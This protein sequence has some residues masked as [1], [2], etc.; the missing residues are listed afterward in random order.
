MDFISI[1]SPAEMDLLPPALMTVLPFVKMPLPLQLG[2]GK[3]V[4]TEISLMP[5]SPRQ[6]PPGTGLRLMPLGLEGSHEPRT[7]NSP[8]A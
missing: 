7:S 5:M 6:S 8:A 3:L 4:S 1:A 2:C